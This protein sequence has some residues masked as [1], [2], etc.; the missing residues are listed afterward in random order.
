MK[1]LHTADLHLGAR[2]GML[3]QEKGAAQRSQLLKTLELIGQTAVSERVDAVIIAGDLFDGNAPSTRSVERVLAV[4]GRLARE[5][6]RV[7][8]IPG[9]HDCYDASSVWRSIDLPDAR[10][11]T[12]FTDETG[13]VSVPELE[14][15]VYGLVF[16]GKK[17]PAGALAGLKRT[18]RDGLHVGIVHGSLA[19]PGVVED[20]SLIFTAEEASATGMDYLA[21]G[22]WHSFRQ[23]RFGNVVACYP[24]APEFVSID[25]TGAG[26]VALV[27]IGRQGGVAVE[28]RTV[29]ARRFESLEVPVDGVASAGDIVQIVRPKADPDLVLDVVLSGLCSFDLEVDPEELAAELRDGFFHLRFRDRSHPMLDEVSVS[30][31]AETTVAGKFARIMVAR[32]EAAEASDKAACEEALRLGVALLEGKRVL[33]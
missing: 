19:I 20:D 25:Q 30:E 31:L 6:I 14:L 10:R 24:G 26:S 12:L 1:I 7:F 8:I 27:D 2:F 17:A 22:H 23:E 33:G 4:A 32:I 29:G 13:P 5:S 28:P 16:P 15:T 9:T 18:G 11:I 3:G 21:L